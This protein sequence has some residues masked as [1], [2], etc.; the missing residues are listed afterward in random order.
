MMNRKIQQDI[1]EKLIAERITLIG[2]AKEKRYIAMD[3]LA[4]DVYNGVSLRE[5]HAT[6][7]ASETQPLQ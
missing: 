3:K 5:A 2:D 6:F 4:D 7:I 1:V